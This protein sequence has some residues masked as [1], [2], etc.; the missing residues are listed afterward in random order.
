MGELWNGNAG[1][2][3]K[4]S[5]AGY[6]VYRDSFNTPAFLDFLPDVVG[7]EGLDIGC[8]EGHNTRLVGRRGAR[9]TGVDIGERFVHHA[10]EEEKREPLGVEYVIADACDLPFEDGRFDFATA[11]MSLMDLPTPDRAIAEAF[12]VLCPGGFLQ[13]S[14]THPCFDTS[15]RRNLRD[16]KGK[17]YAIEVGD[18]FER[19][20]G[21]ITRWLFSSAPEVARTGLP[22]FEVPRFTRTASEWFNMLVDAGFLIARVAEPRPSDETVR[23]FPA[24][25]DTQV[26]AYFLHVRVRRPGNGRV[27]GRSGSMRENESAL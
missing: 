6:D 24:V 10:L 18:Y 1:A 26:V 11:F 20:D 3:A 16:E 15:H 8:G 5:R 7:L 25:Q 12:R 21:R 2:W 27:A 9:M 4:L 23:A 13:F 14:I 19:V 17:T 22:L